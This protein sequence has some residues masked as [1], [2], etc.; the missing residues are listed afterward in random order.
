MKYDYD[1][2]KMTRI[3][4]NY[5]DGVKDDDDNEQWY[6]E[7]GVQDEGEDEEDHDGYDEGK[8]DDED[9]GFSPQ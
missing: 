4:N 7:M 3:N 5:S 8:D 9:D 6:E 2:D 1:M